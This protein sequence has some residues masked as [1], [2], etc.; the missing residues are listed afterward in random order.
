MTCIIIVSKQ[1]IRFK[2]DVVNAFPQVDIDRPIF[3]HL[4]EHPMFDWRDPQTGVT[5]IGLV[6][7]N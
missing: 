6:N 5:D 1:W 2:F 7:G 3:V 4:P